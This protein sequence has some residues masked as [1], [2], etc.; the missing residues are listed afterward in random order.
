MSSH[1]VTARCMLCR[2]AGDM[3]RQEPL[4]F[5]DVRLCRHARRA[6][7]LSRARTPNDG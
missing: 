5:G 6:Q 7:C 1:I 4:G 2:I 3:L